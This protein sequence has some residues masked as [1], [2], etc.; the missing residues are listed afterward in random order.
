M[1]LSPTLFQRKILLTAPK[2]SETQIKKQKF[3]HFQNITKIVLILVFLRPFARLSTSRLRKPATNCIYSQRDVCCSP[4]IHHKQRSSSKVLFN[5]LTFTY[6]SFCALSVR[7]RG[8]FGNE[9]RGFP[10]IF[11]QKIK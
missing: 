9:A 7:E 6:I 8:H 1:H 2:Q 5:F 4:R 10:G 3:C 11:Y